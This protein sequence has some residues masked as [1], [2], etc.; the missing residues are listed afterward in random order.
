MSSVT[1]SMR[2]PSVILA[3]WFGAG[4]SPKAPGT[5][6]S[7]AAVPFAWAIMEGSGVQGLIM[8]V[9]IVFI[10][11]LWA[12]KGYLDLSG[13][14]DPGPVVI[15]E[16]AGQWLCLC[17]VP[18]QWPWFLAGFVLFRVFDILKPWPIG[19]MDRTIK[20][21]FG[22]MIDDIAAGLYAMIILYFI[23]AYL[24]VSS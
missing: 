12:T 3:T 6:G 21:A 7:L 16:V 14:S 17:I 13:D 2:Y 1:P 24:G 18:L 4:L 10:I 19:W 20:G 5:V 15:D 8:A 11:G 23:M 9:V 22:V